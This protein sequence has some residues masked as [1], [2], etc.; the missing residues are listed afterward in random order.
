VEQHPAAPAARPFDHRPYITWS[1]SCRDQ[2]AIPAGQ[3][4]QQFVYIL[5]TELKRKSPGQSQ[6]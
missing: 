5:V 4:I 2:P 3:P 6:G 1:L